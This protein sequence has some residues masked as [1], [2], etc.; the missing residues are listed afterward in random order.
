VRPRDPRAQAE[1]TRGR[2]VIQLI[3]QEAA[4]VAEVYDWS[5]SISEGCAP[6]QPIADAAAASE[7]IQQSSSLRLLCV[8]LRECLPHR[9]ARRPAATTGGCAGRPLT[10]PVAE[11][12]FPMCRL[13]AASTPA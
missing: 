2:D 6:S 9:R 10:P 12:E 3:L 4:E 1:R 5:F 13:H 11:R 8:L 7:L